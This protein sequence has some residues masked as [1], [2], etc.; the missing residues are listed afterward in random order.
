[1][2]YML[3]VHAPESA[4]TRE[5]WTQC[6][7]DSMAI[8]NELAAKGQF[9]TAA[10]LHPVST[11]MTVRVR[12][13]KQLITDGP[14]AETTEQLGGFYIIDASNLDEAIAIAARIPPAKKGTIEIRPIRHLDHLPPDRL[15]ERGALPLASGAEFMFLC[16]DDEEYWTNAGPDA[17]L[18][19]MNEAAALT[20][21]L[22]SNGKFIA[23]AP[24][25]AGSTATSVR[26][27]DGKRIVTDGPFAETREVLGGYY[28]IQAT[29][30]D[31]AVAIAARHSG[32]RVDAV[33]VR[34]VYQLAEPVDTADREIISER[35]LPYPREQVFEAFSHPKRLARW[36]GPAGFR[37]TFHHFQFT[38]GRSWRF[39]MHGP[40]G[41]DYENHNVFESIEA[42]EKIV[43][44]HV[45]APLFRLVIT[46]GELPGGHTRLR[47]VQ[48]FESPRILDA[49]RK[50]IVESNEQNFDRLTA[51]L[52]SN[53]TAEN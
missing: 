48:Q 43:L 2:K 45:C 47:W 3:L 21:E 18:A 44:N 13:Q 4:W 37:N 1:M 46:L 35:N 20:R 41:A 24:L 50:I 17:H 11:A 7:V 23:A 22:A 38:P 25:H 16:Y 19:A 42:P 27:R 49:I 29:D 53:T 8:C 14:F 15:A 26:V 32:A 31:E 12:D 34:P 33:E 39:T 40:D 10:P 52:A 28:L 51:E 9:Q 5:E 30:I 36:W 6:T